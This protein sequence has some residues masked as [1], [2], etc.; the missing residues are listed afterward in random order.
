MRTIRL[1]SIAAL[2]VL[3]NADSSAAQGASSAL[4]NTLEVRQLVSRGE[5]GDSA[6]LSAHF[7]ALADRYA[8][9]ATRHDAMAQAF[10]ASPTRRTPTNSAADHCER[11]ARL[12]KESADTLRELRKLQPEVPVL[13]SSGYSSDEDLRAVEREGV[14]GF[15]AK[16]Y[17][18]ADLARRVRGALDG[19]KNL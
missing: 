3:L 6:R 4:L 1:F 19:L 15:V 11:L 18:P 16:P 14:L 5:P 2:A 8:R 7:A 10:I 12:N 17:R 9:E 13:I